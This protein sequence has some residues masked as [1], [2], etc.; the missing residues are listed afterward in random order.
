MKC[1][2]IL[3]RVA[4]RRQQMSNNEQQFEN[5]EAVGVDASSET[6]PEPACK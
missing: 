1:F 2:N 5:Y 3:E 4:G 6:T